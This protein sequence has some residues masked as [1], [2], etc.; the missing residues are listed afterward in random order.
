MNQKSK[1][2]SNL[3]FQNPKINRSGYIPTYLMNLSNRWFIFMIQRPILSQ[4]GLHISI[5]AYASLCLHNFTLR[6]TQLWAY[7]SINSCH[8]ALNGICNPPWVRIR[9]TPESGAWINT[10]F[11]VTVAS[12]SLWV[13]LAGK[14]AQ[15][16]LSEQCTGSAPLCLSNQMS[17]VQ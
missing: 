12:N 5:Y 8:L 4:L 3:D 15:V 17:V 2:F 10:G 7:R 16:E 13:L 6:S 9:S 11:H 14:P 1:I